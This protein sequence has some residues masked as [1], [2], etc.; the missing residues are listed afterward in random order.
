[1]KKLGCMAAFTAFSLVTAGASMSHGNEGEDMAR[2]GVVSC[3]GTN[4]LRQGNTEIHFTNYN[5]RNQNAS[6]PIRVDRIVVYAATGVVLFDSEVNGFPLFESARIGPDDQLLDPKQS[7]Q[8]GTDTFLPFLDEPLRPLQTEFTWSA[9]ERVLSLQ[10]ST[11]RVARQFA[12]PNNMGQERSRE[13]GRCR[14]VSLHR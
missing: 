4:F 14:N 1:M 6:T 12:L 9:P 7:A 11:T 2:S 3:G 10:V 5:L 8:L 13:G